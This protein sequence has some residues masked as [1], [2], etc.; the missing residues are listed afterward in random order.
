ME[1]EQKR[2]R[3]GFRGP[4]SFLISYAVHLSRGSLVLPLMGEVQV[5][6]LI[7]LELDLPNDETISDDA[8]VLSVN[9]DE[10]P[11]SLSV[12]IALGPKLSDITDTLVTQYAHEGTRLRVLVVAPDRH[13]RQN[14]KRSVRSTVASAQVGFAQ[15]AERAAPLLGD[16]PDL[17]V[18]DLGDE[19]EQTQTLWSI[20][21][22]ANPPLPSLLI[23][24]NQPMADELKRYGAW[25]VLVAPPSSAEFR[26]SVLRALARPVVLEDDL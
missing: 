10:T 5:G 6:E 21:Q 15:S 9:A 14:L 2:L 22:S 17:A 25:D 13:T 4:S 8:R 19:L 20:C 3:L 1:D 23:A 11:A 24:E 16:V 18:I 7:R 12:E 26:R